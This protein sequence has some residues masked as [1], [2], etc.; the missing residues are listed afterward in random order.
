MK[1]YQKP[2]VICPEVALEDCTKLSAA[3][4]QTDLKKEAGKTAGLYGL[5][6]FK[7]QLVKECYLAT[8]EQKD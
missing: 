7:H 1:L 8:Q 3:N 2:I 6:S 4:H 5:C